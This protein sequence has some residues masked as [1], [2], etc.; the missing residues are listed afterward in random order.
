MAK[1]IDYRKAVETCIGQT[2]Y[3]P[4]SSC[5]PRTDLALF[6]PNTECNGCEQLNARVRELEAELAQKVVLSKENTD[7]S[8]STATLVG[9]VECTEPTVP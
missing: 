9:T 8:T 1:E 7:G 2:M 3:V 6:I 4:R 5:D